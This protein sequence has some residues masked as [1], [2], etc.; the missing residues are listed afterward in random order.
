M[1]RSKNLALMFLLGAVLV[2]GALGFTAD[3]VILG[4]REKDNSRASFYDEL[5][6]SEVQRAS[7]DSILDDRHRKFN[8]LLKPIRPQMDSVR[9]NA[10]DAMRAVLNPEQRERYE[11]ILASQRRNSTRR[12]ESTK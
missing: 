3:R 11:N 6:L 12:E 8:E 9:E 4:N 5:G 7:F 1:Q 2:G 10:R